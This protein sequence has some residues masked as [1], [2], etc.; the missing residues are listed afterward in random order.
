MLKDL[1]K[2]KYVKLSF[3]LKLTVICLIILTVLTIMGTIYQA[4]NGLYK[5]KLKFFSSWFFLAGGFIPLPG[6]ALVMSILFVNLV[7][8]MIFRIGIRLK[9]IGNFLTHLGILILLLGGFFTFF[10]SEESV[11]T[12]R[13]GENSSW[14]SSYHAWELSVW[15]DIEGVRHYSVINLEDLNPGEK[16]NFPELPI[17]IVVKKYFKNSSAFKNSNIHGNNEIINSSGIVSVDFKEESSEP[18]ENIPGIILHSD[19]VNK[20]IIL[21]GGERIPAHLNLDGEIYN[22]FLRKSRKKLPLEIK[23]IDFRI[24]KYP[25]SEIV[26]SYES[27]VEIKHDGLVREVLISMN[28]PLRYK[29]YTFFQSSY[30]IT[31][32][33]I[34]YSILAVVKN[35]GRLLPY[36]SSIIIFIGMLIHFILMLFRKKK[37]KSDTPEGN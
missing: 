23:L 20:D 13:E 18:A 36:I 22:F 33:G 11:L 30:Q 17:K 2:N 6:A 15:K 21:Y 16:L 35:S 12:L 25:G 34:E 1:K 3:S 26:K 32:G 4:D 8:S 24:K 7:S 14:S 29:D 27:K 31:P 5:A 9:N 28:K 37:I 10:F 19:D